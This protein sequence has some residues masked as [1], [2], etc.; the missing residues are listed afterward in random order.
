M[1]TR[2]LYHA[3]GVRGYRLVCT[4]FENSRVWFGIEHD[5]RSLRR[6]PAAW[7]SGTL[8]RVRAE[9]HTGRER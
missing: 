3:W 1:S 7:L 8:E 2:L 4:R 9:A 6:L 5:E